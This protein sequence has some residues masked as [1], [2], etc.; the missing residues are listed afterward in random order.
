LL[1]KPDQCRGVS[2]CSHLFWS[3]RVYGSGEGEEEEEEE[4]E[5]VEVSGFYITKS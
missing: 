5:S 2:S 1:K 3:G 4:K